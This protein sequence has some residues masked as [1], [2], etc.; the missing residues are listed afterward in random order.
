MT[1]STARRL[2][3]NWFRDLFRK[4]RRDRLRK[5][6]PAR[7]RP[8]VE[9][10]EDRITPVHDLGLFQLDRNALIAVDR[11]APNNFGGDDWDLLNTQYLAGDTTPGNSAAFT[12]ILADNT[13]VNP[14]G[15]IGTQFQ[16]GGSKDNNDISQWLWNPG[17]PLDKDDITD[18]YA[19]AY[20]N[21][22]DTGNNNV[23]DLIL[24]YGLDRFANNG[25]AQVGAW[26]FQNDI[27]LTTTAQSGGF[28]FSGV[29]AVGDILVQSNFTQGGVISSITVFC[30]QSSLHCGGRFSVWGR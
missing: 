27:G 1:T 20:I 14:L 22:T 6:T 21:T 8:R 16:G 28:K 18:G 5:K 3:T 29:H 12:G 10:L 30:S 15:S 17:E 23:G 4:P 25:S 13:A 19:A 24:Y 7:I 26:F 11:P 9:R 2:P